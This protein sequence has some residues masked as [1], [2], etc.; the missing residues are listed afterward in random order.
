MALY[1]IDDSIVDVMRW[2]HIQVF[3]KFPMRENTAQNNS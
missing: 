1:I 3:L 2:A